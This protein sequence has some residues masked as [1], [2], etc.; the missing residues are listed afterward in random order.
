MCG[1]A[2]CEVGCRRERNRHTAPD[3]IG[4][5]VAEV[6]GALL[7]ARRLP[8][9]KFLPEWSA[10]GKQR[11]ELGLESEDDGEL[12][13]LRSV[14]LHCQRIAE[15]ARGAVEYALPFDPEFFLADE[16]PAVEGNVRISQLDNVHEAPVR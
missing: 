5:V 12:G 4:P 16:L 7:P 1:G 10:H 8:F 14:V 6:Q 2:V 3:L 13:R 11:L 15:H 9:A